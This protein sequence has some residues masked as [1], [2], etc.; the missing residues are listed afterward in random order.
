MSV[1]ARKLTLEESTEPVSKV[2]LN[3]SIV[4]LLILVVFFCG[5]S[6]VVVN[7][8]KHVIDTPYD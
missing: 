3:G 2:L 4:T 1:E 8:V 7:S 5:V 6:V